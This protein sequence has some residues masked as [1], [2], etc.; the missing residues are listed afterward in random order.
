MQVQVPHGV[1]PGQPFTIL[2]PQG[3]Q[4]AFYAP[5]GSVPG[6]IVQVNLPAIPQAATAAAVAPQ[7]M[8]RAA[9]YGFTGDEQNI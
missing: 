3:Q 9:P 4:M 5:P 1:M 7:C 2:T 8:Q 6:Q